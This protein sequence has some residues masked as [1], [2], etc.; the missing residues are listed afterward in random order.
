MDTL[1]AEVGGEVVVMSLEQGKYY[2]FDEVGSDVWRRIEQPIVVSQ[3]CAALALE[4]DADP[5]VIERDTIVLLEK[6]ADQSL[7]ETVHS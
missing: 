4:Y 7:L 1:A 5:D 2:G 3:L 6:L